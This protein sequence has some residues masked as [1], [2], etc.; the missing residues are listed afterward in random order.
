[1]DVIA[2]EPGGIKTPIW[3]K[4]GELANEI[5]ADMTAEGEQLYGRMMAAVRRQTAKIEHVRGLPPRAVAEVIG[6]ALTADRQ[7]ARYVI[8]R[9]AKA[10][11]VVAG[12]APDRVMDGLIERVLG[13]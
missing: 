2:I 8:G 7:R 10:R 6:T 5:A 1:V 9:D 12:V 13:G 3:R 11:A 4:G